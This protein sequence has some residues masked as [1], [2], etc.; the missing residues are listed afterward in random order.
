MTERSDLAALVESFTR[1]RVLCVGDVMLDRYIYGEV[2][3]ISPEAPIPVF[4]I[5]RETAMVGGAGNVARNIA[6]LGAW[7]RLVG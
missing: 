3:R 2:E 6:A 1:A 5:E 7:T 4:R